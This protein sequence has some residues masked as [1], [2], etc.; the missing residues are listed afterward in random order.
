MSHSREGKPVWQLSSLTKVLQVESEQAP[1]PV[2]QRVKIIMSAGLM[3]VHTLSRW[4][5]DGN[6]FNHD[7]NSSSI[8]EIPVFYSKENIEFYETHLRKWFVVGYEQLVMVGLVFALAIKYIF[9]DSKDTENLIAVA[10][11]SNEEERIR[12]NVEKQESRKSSMKDNETP[13]I[14]VS[15]DSDTESAIVEG[16]KRTNSPKRQPFFIGDDFS[17]DCSEDVEVADKEIQTDNS[18]IAEVL[19]PF[20]PKTG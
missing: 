5:L 17:S 3:L 20:K 16:N 18:T 11:Q 19:G 9:F 13:I 6:N 1:N 2:I 15:H 7:K 8:E 4:Q 10:K 12:S 14:L